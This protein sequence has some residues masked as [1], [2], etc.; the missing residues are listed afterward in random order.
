MQNSIYFIAIYE[1]SILEVFLIL[2]LIE[3]GSKTVCW[4][5]DDDSFLRDYK[6]E[7]KETK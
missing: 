6:K 7:L 1:S 5:A 2:E 4:E 3:W